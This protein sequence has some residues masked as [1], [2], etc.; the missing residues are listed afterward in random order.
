MLCISSS[1]DRRRRR[2]GVRGAERSTT[3][4]SVVVSIAVSC[5][6]P[7][8]LF[9]AT[10]PHIEKSNEVGAPPSHNKSVIIPK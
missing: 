9:R 7:L 1:P 10:A 2:D 5:D 6:R 8:E 3:G 4:G